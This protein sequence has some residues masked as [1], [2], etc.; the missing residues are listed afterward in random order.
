MAND[1]LRSDR[2]SPEISTFLTSMA[3][4]DMQEDYGVQAD[5]LCCQLS[6]HR[7]EYTG[8]DAVVHGACLL[9]LVL[10]LIV[11]I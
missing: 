11:R 3:Y 2:E 7:V 1:G 8:W 9:V 10:V 6:L 4:T 5:V